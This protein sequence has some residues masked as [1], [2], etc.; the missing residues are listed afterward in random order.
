MPKCAELHFISLNCVLSEYRALIML[1]FVVLQ[2]C[3][4]CYY[5]AGIM[6]GS[7]QCHQ[8]HCFIMSCITVILYCFVLYCIVSRPIHSYSASYNARQS[9]APPVREGLF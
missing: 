7:L 9:E 4:K 1:N 8:L 6:H 2:C 3:I 5:I